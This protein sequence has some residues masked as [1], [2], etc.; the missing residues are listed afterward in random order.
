MIP[1][2]SWPVIAF[3]SLFLSIFGGMNAF[4]FLRW[5]QAFQ[6][7][8]RFSIPIGVFLCLMV[9]APMI[10]A[11]SASFPWFALRR[12]F[13]LVGL[14]WMGIALLFFVLA[15]TIDLLRRFLGLSGHTAFELTPSRRSRLFLLETA[16]IAG[17]VFYGTF[18]AKNI[19]VINLRITS[20]KIR[21]KT[22]IAHITDVHMSILEDQTCAERVLERIRP[23]QP[24]LLVSTG[25]LIDH[26]LK[27]QE[28]CERLFREF[29]VRLGKLA[30][31]GNHEYYAGLD[32][33]CG[34]LERS[35]FTLLRRTSRQVLPGLIV[36]GVDD[37]AANRSG[38]P[39]VILEEAFLRTLPAEAFILL[40][41]HQPNVPLGFGD[42]FDLQLSGHTHHGQIFPFRFLTALLNQFNYGYHS[43]G[44]G[45]LYVSGGAGTW[46]PP[47]RFL[48]PPEI[49][50]IDLIP[51][52]GTSPKALST[53]HILP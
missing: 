8:K 53:L 30:V 23:F 32:F 44:R 2:I 47:F 34:F 18:E 52:T 13:A 17:I 14:S 49:T 50:I 4:F 41:K 22:R 39:T 1:W 45:E 3:F 46:G 37:P 15:I 43:F 24:D 29:P 11:R 51:A 36:A 40:L 20:P 7:R 12:A 21:E 9:F 27:N 48:T 16:I 5:K 19:R 28:A 42:L 25:D 31:I 38:S 10:V 26:P 6:P 33:S 35:D